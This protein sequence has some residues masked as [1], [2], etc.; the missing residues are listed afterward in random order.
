M[1]PAD[2]GRDIAGGHERPL[3]VDHGLHGAAHILDHVRPG[4][5]DLVLV[6][7][8]RAGHVV[9]ASAASRIT[10]GATPGGRT[11]VTDPNATPSCAAASSA[12]NARSGGLRIRHPGAASPTA[13]STRSCRER[14]CRAVGHRQT[15]APG[16][17]HPAQLTAG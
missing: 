17:Q 10:T 8:A 12:A 16:R 9:R 6:V 1:L 15:G 5:G 4:P 14:I 13:R 7:V 11:P 2:E 3:V